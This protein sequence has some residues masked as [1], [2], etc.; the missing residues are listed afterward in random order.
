MTEPR[1]L[2]Q[3]FNVIID[4]GEYVPA[5]G[6]CIAAIAARRK[7]YI[8]PVEAHLATEAAR[9]YIGAP[10]CVFLVDA[11]HDSDLPC[12][13]S[14]CIHIYLNWDHRPQLS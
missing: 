14:D 2:Q 12:S 4:S 10:E 7:G 11:L 9:D 6:M 8:T 1:S 13:A 5:E 3:I